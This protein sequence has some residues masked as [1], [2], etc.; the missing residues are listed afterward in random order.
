MVFKF[1]TSIFVAKGCD[2]TAFSGVHV[3]KSNA[4]WDKLYSASLFKNIR[5]IEGMVYEDQE[6]ILRIFSEA[7]NIAL[8]NK[9]LY[10][11]F[12]R[13]NSN[14][15]A[16]GQ[17]SEQRHDLLVAR[18]HMYDTCAKKYPALEQIARNRYLEAAIAYLYDSRVLEDSKRIRSNVKEEINCFINEHGGIKQRTDL[19]LAI[20]AMNTNMVIFDRLCSLRDKR[21]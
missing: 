12:R 5:M 10:N 6:V 8:T 18:L 11:Y 17:I 2:W 21:R 7:D 3:F 19:M 9:R 4:L 14:T 13:L 1:N 20:L 15:I 16:Q